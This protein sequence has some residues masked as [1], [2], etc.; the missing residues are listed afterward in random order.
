MAFSELYSGSATIGSTEYSLTNNST[1]IASQTT[2]AVVTPVVDLT[3]MQA[4]DK[5]EVRFI[6]KVASSDSQKNVMP[7][8]VFEGK[9]TSPQY[10]PPVQVLHGWDVTVRKLAGTDRTIVWSIRGVT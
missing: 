7:P 8:A 2:D 10:F 9:Q 5:Y 6:E 1:T 4:G 3:A